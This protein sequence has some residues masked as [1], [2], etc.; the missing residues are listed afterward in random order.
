VRNSEFIDIRFQ[1]DLKGIY[2][3]PNPATGSRGALDNITYQNIYDLRCAVVTGI[4]QHAAEASAHMRLQLHRL[5]LHLPCAGFLPNPYP[6]AHRTGG[7]RGV[8][9][10]RE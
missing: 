5:Q 9:G 4:D 6:G 8:R 2:V 3:K 1:N 10:Q 7:M